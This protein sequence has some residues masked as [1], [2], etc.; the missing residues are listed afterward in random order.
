MVDLV[1]LASAF[2]GWQRSRDLFGSLAANVH[3]WRRVSLGDGGNGD[4]PDRRLGGSAAARR[5]VSES[6]SFGK[7]AHRLSSTP[8]RRLCCLVDSFADNLRHPA[9]IPFGLRI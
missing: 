7:L 3:P 4:A 8:S 6:A 9:D 2:A 1:G 5:A